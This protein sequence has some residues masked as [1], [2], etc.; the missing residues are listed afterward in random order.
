MQAPV[1]GREEPDALSIGATVLVPIIGRGLEYMYIY[2]LGYPYA[3][4]YPYGTGRVH[5]P[6]THFGLTR[7]PLIRALFIVHSI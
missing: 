2:G 6:A 5:I 3:T 7:R 1:S 4:G